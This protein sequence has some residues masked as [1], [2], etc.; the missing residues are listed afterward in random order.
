MQLS[1]D[2]LSIF[3]D[4]GHY[5]SSSQHSA[6]SRT[7]QSFSFTSAMTSTVAASTAGG[8]VSLFD[9]VMQMFEAV[10]QETGIEVNEMALLVTY[11]ENPD[12]SP[13]LQE[14]E[15]QFLIRWNK[16]ASESP[17]QVPRPCSGCNM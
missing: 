5:L 8:V 17:G 4:G 7:S 1:H 13:Q 3:V 11:M 2:Q 14:Q 9:T 12:K 15:T 6:Q 10:S 16:E